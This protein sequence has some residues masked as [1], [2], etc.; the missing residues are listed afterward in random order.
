MEA[1]AQQQGGCRHRRRNAVA[2]RAA[3]RRAVPSGTA[4]RPAVGEVSTAT[5][6]TALHS[7][8]G[9]AA[10]AAGHSDGAGSRGADGGEDRVGADLRGGLSTVQLRFSSAP[11]RYAGFGGHG[12]TGGMN[13][14]TGGMQ[15]W[16]MF[17]QIF[18]KVWK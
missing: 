5:G 9:W 13:S 6:T 2:D 17:R 4:R 16:Q 7:Q 15:Q 1:G 14:S 11:Q 8:G 18:S 10:A 12:A 3:R